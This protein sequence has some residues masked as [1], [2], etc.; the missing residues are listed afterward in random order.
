MIG[1]TSINVQQHSRTDSRK[2]IE[3]RSDIKAA[4]MFAFNDD[5]VDVSI[6]ARLGD[7]SIVSQPKDKYHTTS[8]QMLNGSREIRVHCLDISHGYVH[9][10][11]RTTLKPTEM[12]LFSVLNQS[13]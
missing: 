3:E 9:Y 12:N 1:L 4:S 6:Y 8:A 5:S 11:C 13:H 2:F 10:R 7:S